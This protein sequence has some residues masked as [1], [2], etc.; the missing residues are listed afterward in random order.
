MNATAQ[1]PRPTL[2]QCLDMWDHIYAQDP[3]ADI[4]TIG[5]LFEDWLVQNGWTHAQYVDALAARIQ[6]PKS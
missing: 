6:V 5:D 4:V 1:T 2:D 3:G